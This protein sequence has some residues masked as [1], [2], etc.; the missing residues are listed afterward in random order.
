MQTTGVHGVCS[1]GE[2]ET[3]KECGTA[4]VRAKETEIERASERERL[5]E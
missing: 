5:K 2:V 1:I 3:E 4:R